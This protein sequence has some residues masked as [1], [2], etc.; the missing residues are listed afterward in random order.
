VN[1]FVFLVIVKS[2]NIALNKK[3]LQLQAQSNQEI[4]TNNKNNIENLISKLL[5]TPI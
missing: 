1:A 2:Y 5:K 4:K 3:K